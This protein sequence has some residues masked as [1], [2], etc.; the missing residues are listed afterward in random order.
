MSYSGAG[1]TGRVVRPGQALVLEQEPAGLVTPM[2][3][4]Q[5][6]AAP[7]A[8]RPMPAPSPTPGPIAEELER[9]WQTR[10]QEAHRAGITEGEILGKQRAAAT[11]EPVIARLSQAIAELA[12]MRARLRKEAEG[13]TVKLALAIARRVL[14]RE[15]TVDPDALHGLLRAALERLQ[16]Q[17][18]SRVRVHPSQAGPVSVYLEKTGCGR[19]VD[20][21]A[22]PSREPGDAIFETPRGNLDVSVESQLREIE[23]GLTDRLGASSG[24]LGKQ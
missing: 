7:V 22:D 10:V 19:V 2:V 9:Q 3:W 21:V 15:V 14:R 4:K 24:S 16:G 17:E 18:I 8:H 6:G 12:Q 5:V 11:I 20:V 13:D 23:R 1:A